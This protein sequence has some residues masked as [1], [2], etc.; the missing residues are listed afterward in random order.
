MVPNTS[1]QGLEP[2]ELLADTKRKQLES[3]GLRVTLE[4]PCG[5]EPLPRL[6]VRRGTWL[7]IDRTPVEQGDVLS[8][9][10][11]EDLP[12]GA[13][14]TNFTSYATQADCQRGLGKLIE[15]RSRAGA[16]AAEARRR[17]LQEQ[18]LEQQARATRAC[19]QDEAVQKRCAEVGRTG[20]RLDRAQCDVERE[21]TER[22]CKVARGLVEQLRA[23]LEIGQG[24][25]GAADAP[26]CRKA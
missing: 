13:T 10:F 25:A 12:R 9:G 20:H 19:E 3:L 4:R 15:A 26:F 8:F 1:A 14:V 22:E 11:G 17:W 24:D 21:H 23:R 16:E 2:C 6:A 5:A 7:L 18:R